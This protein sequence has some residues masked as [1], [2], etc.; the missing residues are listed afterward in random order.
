MLYQHFILIIVIKCELQHNDQSCYS[1]L[2]ILAKFIKK[3]VNFHLKTSS[4]EST[5]FNLNLAD[6]SGT[7]IHTDSNVIGL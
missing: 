1:H 3:N 5:S 4:I 7:L 6:Q 2:Y